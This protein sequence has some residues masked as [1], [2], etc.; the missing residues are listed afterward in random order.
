MVLLACL[1]Y[2]IKQVRPETQNYGAGGND[3]FQAGSTNGLPQ[4]VNLV[5]LEQHQNPHELENTV[6]R[7]YQE[8]LRA[9]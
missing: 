8:R 7:P 6:P 1:V 4:Q 9:K 5:E 3:Y 2:Y